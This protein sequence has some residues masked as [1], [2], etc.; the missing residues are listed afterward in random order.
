MVMLVDG[1]EVWGHWSGMCCCACLVVAAVAGT[2]S[3]L[4]WGVKIRI[5]LKWGE[6]GWEEESEDVCL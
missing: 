6:G 2:A 1:L 4:V 5:V 3:A